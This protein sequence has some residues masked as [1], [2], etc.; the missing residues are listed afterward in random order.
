LNTNVTQT[1]I[2]GLIRGL[3]GILGTAKNSHA[4]KNRE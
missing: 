4:Y 1:T 3:V 2:G